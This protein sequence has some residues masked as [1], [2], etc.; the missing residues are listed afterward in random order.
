METRDF[1]N[2]MP[3]LIKEQPLE[4][5]KVFAFYDEIG[6]KTIRL[7]SQELSDALSCDITILKDTISKLDKVVALD[8]YP[9]VKEG[10]T[11]SSESLLEDFN[12]LNRNNIKKFKF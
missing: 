12:K 9:F 7:N 8:Y 10:M 1:L 11:A 6:Q 5:Q 3:M 2:S 4:E